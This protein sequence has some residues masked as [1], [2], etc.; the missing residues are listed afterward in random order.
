MVVDV[1]VVL[2]AFA[3]FAGLA[4]SWVVLPGG[5]RQPTHRVEA[6]PRISVEP[7]A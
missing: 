2:A 3:A 5:T 1:A 4:L 7:A 6:A